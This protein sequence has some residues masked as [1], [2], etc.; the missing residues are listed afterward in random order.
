MGS[1]H[2]GPVRLF[3][4]LVILTTLMMI[5]LSGPAT[6]A[7][8][9]EHVS[10]HFTVLSNASE[11]N[12]VAL[13]RDLEKFRVAMQLSIGLRGL[14]H[15]LPVQVIHIAD[16]QTFGRFQ[17]RSEEKAYGV[18]TSR[19]Y[20]LVVGPEGWL[21]DARE[22]V[23]HEYAHYLLR[24]VSNVVYPVWYEE[25]IA[26]L[27]SSTTIDANTVVIGLAPKSV[28]T[29]FSQ[30]KVTLRLE[31]VLEATDV[32]SWDANERAEFQGVSWALVHYLH[33]ELPTKKVE[34][35]GALVRKY[36][37]QHNAGIKPRKALK[38][39]LNMSYRKL[40]RAL[41][42]FLRKGE[43]QTLTFSLPGDVDS[44]KIG[45]RLLQSSEAAYGLGVF[46]LIGLE[47]LQH[48][49]SYLTDAVRSQTLAV[50]ASSALAVLRSRQGRSRSAI[51]LGSD[52]IAS[53]SD[54][55]PALIDLAEVLLR[56]AD[57]ETA[58]AERK[59]ALLYQS[60]G[61]LE[62]ALALHKQLPAAYILLSRTYSLDDADIPKAIPL[63]P[64]RVCKSTVESR[65]AIRAGSVVHENALP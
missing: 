26:A 63:C 47:H 46:A 31:K 24:N 45:T 35:R 58:S 55:P 34:S 43:L 12:A 33:S 37:D 50:R 20:Y 57:D 19:G 14:A 42:K 6:A 25:G 51:A 7:A 52:V 39:A 48:A 4:R 8:W 10:P 13:T 59:N 29:F 3:R 27:L 17:R 56:A 41:E 11:A 15:R 23:F 32:A 54:E 28:E 2:A 49:E 1:L 38:D 61:L 60:R 5:G 9:R 36:L 18:A 16:Q 30:Q 65:H 44:M 22:A 62:R 53:V 64:R 21:A 40:G